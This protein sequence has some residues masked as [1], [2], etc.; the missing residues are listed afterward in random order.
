MPRKSTKVLTPSQKQSSLLKAASNAV[1]NGAPCPSKEELIARRQYND[2]QAELFR[3]TYERLAANKPDLR[4]RRAHIAGKRAASNG[5][6][7]ATEEALMRRNGYTKLQAEVYH[8]AF[9]E[10]AGTPEQQALRRART[11]GRRAA[12]RGSKLPSLKSITQ[13]FAFTPLQLQE[14]IQSFQAY[15]DLHSESIKSN[16]DNE[17][18]LTD[19]DLKFVEALLSEPL[20]KETTV[21]H[22]HQYCSGEKGACISEE[23]LMCLERLLSSPSEDAALELRHMPTQATTPLWD[24]LQMESTTLEPENE[25]YKPPT[26][27]RC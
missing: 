25:A 21:Y 5:C 17:V 15:F 23:P 12:A 14:Y 27:K 2:E 13:T 1:S 22:F 6:V 7:L 3:T 24:A 10:S 18:S 8:K 26:L 19:A 11:A 16:E 4:T 9:L 20:S